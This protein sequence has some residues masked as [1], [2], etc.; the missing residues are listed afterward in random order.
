YQD[1]NQ[2]LEIAAQQR[3]DLKQA[4]A[5]EQASKFLMYSN[6]GNFLPSINAQYNFGTRYNQ[7]RGSDKTDPTF[8]DFS[9]QFFTDNVYHQAGIG[10]SIPIFTGFQNRATYVQSKVL[11]EN[12]KIQTRNREVIV[13]GDV[14]RA[15]SNFESVKKAY[16]VSVE[17]LEASK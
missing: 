5:T 4:K 14:V 2:L 9:D 11:F 1:L 6:R 16:T 8:R 3:S 15:Y 7:V 10:V 13:K 12:N 17:G